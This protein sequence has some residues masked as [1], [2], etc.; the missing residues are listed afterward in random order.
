MN[1]EELVAYIKRNYKVDPDHPF[2]KEYD[3]MVFRH[4][5]TGKWFALVMRVR[6]DKLGYKGDEMMDII[7]LKSE[8]MLI[9]SL[10]LKNGIHRAYHMNKQQWLSLELNEKVSDGEI[11][12]LIALSYELTD[13]KIKRKGM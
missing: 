4:I 10:V 7:N 8:P 3:S 5:D 13:K 1:R 11:E 6:K 12:N 2:Q 9:D